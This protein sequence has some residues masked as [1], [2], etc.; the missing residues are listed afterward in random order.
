MIQNQLLWPTGL[1]IKISKKLRYKVKRARVAS[2]I[3]GGCKIYVC[4]P[5]N[6]FTCPN[7]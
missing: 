6:I 3:K 4:M 1:S 2:K 7:M 5:T